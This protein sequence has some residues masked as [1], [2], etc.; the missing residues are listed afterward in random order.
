MAVNF[1]DSTEITTKPTMGRTA[2]LGYERGGSF[3]D[4]FT[5]NGITGSHDRRILP[6]N[7][8]RDHYGIL[9]NKSSNQFRVNVTGAYYVTS[10]VSGHVWNH[11][12]PPY[13]Y[14]NSAGG[15]AHRCNNALTGEES[16][17]HLQPGY[18]AG[19]DSHYDVGQMYWVSTGV[20]YGIRYSGENSGG[21]GSSTNYL[22]GGYQQGGV[23]IA[24]D[25]MR[26]SITL[27]EKI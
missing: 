19:D 16:N 27:M 21:L 1:S 7:S 14:D 23:Q 18:T 25:L 26:V 3:M 4:M 20:N 13:L 17:I 5:A 22:Q 11:Y 9:N 12:F 24:L 6:I 15:F 10:W 2:F 8:Y